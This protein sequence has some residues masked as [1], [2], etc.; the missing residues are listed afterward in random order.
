MSLLEVKDLQVY[1]GSIHAIKGVSLGLE[2]FAGVRGLCRSL[3]LRLLHKWRK[4]G[5]SEVRP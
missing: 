1:Y 4:L 5:E 2:L 3:V